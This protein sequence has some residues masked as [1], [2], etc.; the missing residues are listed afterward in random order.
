MSQNSQEIWKVDLDYYLERYA[1]GEARQAVSES[2]YGV[3]GLLINLQNKE[4]IGKYE[5]L[6]CVEQLAPVYLQ[7]RKDQG[8]SAYTLTTERS[9]LGKLFGRPVEFAIEA[10]TPDKITRSRGPRE[11]DRHF[12]AERNKALLVIARGTGGRREDIASMKV[13]H[14]RQIGGHWYVDI[15]KSKGGKDRTAPVRPDMEQEVM[16]I[17][18]QARAAGRDKL[19]DRIN[20]KFDIHTCRRQYAKKLHRIARRNRGLRDELAQIYPPRYEPKIKGDTYTTSCVHP[21]K[22]HGKISS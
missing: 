14:F 2:S 22:P 16:K 5:R 20:C 7:H 17:V 10:W 15:Y 1:L 19:F 3:G 18:T 13:E 21:G 4:I 8:K 12:R 11:M 9:A 6:E